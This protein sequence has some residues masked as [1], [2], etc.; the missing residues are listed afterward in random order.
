VYGITRAYKKEDAQKNKSIN[1]ITPNKHM[2][3][4]SLQDISYDLIKSKRIFHKTTIKSM[5]AEFSIRQQSSLWKQNIPYDDNQVYGTKFFHKTTI[6][7]M[8]T[9][10]FMRQQSSL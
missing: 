2:M 9:E 5:E 10:F 1:G 4:I 8:E 7:F 6:K 3:Q